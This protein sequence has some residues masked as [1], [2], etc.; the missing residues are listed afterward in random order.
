MASTL[1]CWVGVGGR[2]KDRM[3]VRNTAYAIYSCLLLALNVV[4]V[5]ASEELWIYGE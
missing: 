2:D 1:G 4:E 3:W 5:D